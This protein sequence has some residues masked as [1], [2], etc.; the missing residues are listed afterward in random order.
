M[1]K[2]KNK[3]LVV[4]LGLVICVIIFT[5]MIPPIGS[6]SASYWDSFTFG[7]DSWITSAPSES[8]LATFSYGG[9]TYPALVAVEYGNGRAV[10]AEG[11]TFSQTGASTSPRHQIFVN[12]VKWVTKDKDPSDTKILATY[13]HRELLTYKYGSNVVLALQNQR[14]TVDVVFDIPSS[15]ADYDAV[16]MPGVGWS[17]YGGGWVNPDWWSG[18]SGHA[19]TPSEVSSLLS[20]VQNGGGLVSSV[21][22]I[23]GASWMNPIGN[24]MGVTFNYISLASPLIGYRIIEHPIL[25]KWEP[26]IPEISVSKEFLPSEITSISQGVISVTNITNIGDVDLTSISITDDYVENM[27]FNESLGVFVTITSDEGDI[28]AIMPGDL[29]INFTDSDITISFELPLE[30]VQVFWENGKLWFKEDLY[31]LESIPNG[32]TVGIAYPLYLMDELEVG[33][34]D[35]EVTVT[36]YSETGVTT[37]T[38]IGT[39]IVLELL[40][41]VEIISLTPTFMSYCK[42]I[43]FYC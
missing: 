14:Y 9:K 17:W 36:A 40:E 13:G 26:K 28:Y 29:N 22:A 31:H 23:N 34:Y 42:S 5:M 39:L 38:A 43:N 2:K 3:A 8:I 19:P 35:A 32:W 25:L 20:F 18:S 30:V 7:A 10:Y 37:E 27:V 12:S 33:E 15:L 21:E 1:K 6:L 11:S 4:W 41:P 24:P 16:I